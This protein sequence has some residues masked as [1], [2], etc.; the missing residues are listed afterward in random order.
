MTTLGI[1]SLVL[2]GS[3]IPPI[4]I[5]GGV[6]KSLTEIVY[7]ESATIFPGYYTALFDLLLSDDLEEPFNVDLVLISSNYDVWYLLLVEP[8]KDADIDSLKANLE[9]VALQRF[10]T[11]EALYLEKQIAALDSGRLA[12]LIEEQPRLVVVTDDPHN[13]WSERFAAVDFDVT[14]MTVEAFQYG[15]KYV[16]RING[17]YP[18]PITGTVVGM[19][20]E[21]PS[22]PT[23]MVVKWSSVLPRPEPGSFEIRYGGI[24][25]RWQ[26]WHG[27]PDL[28]IVPDSSSPLRD[29]PPFEL[30]QEMGGSYSF[31][32][33][34]EGTNSP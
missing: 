11:R 1:P 7:S 13:K 21:Y 24:L 34:S 9:T 19:C 6:T 28:I 5:Y 2:E 4:R 16:L 32:K 22:L 12:L 23:G 8:S 30:V 10:S 29:K 18:N 27:N 33:Y 3:W 25:T 14:V 17:S 20:S 15:D 26:L 31:R